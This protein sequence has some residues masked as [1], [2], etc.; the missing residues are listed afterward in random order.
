MDLKEYDTAY[1]YSVDTIKAKP[2]FLV[3]LYNICHILKEKKLNIEEIKENYK[4]ISSLIF[5]ENIL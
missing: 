3:P 4:K 1:K 5:Q 2:D